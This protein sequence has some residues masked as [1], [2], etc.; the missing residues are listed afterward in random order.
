MFFLWST[1][2]QTSQTYFTLWYTLS[3]VYFIIIIFFVDVTLAVSFFHLFYINFI[4]F[5]LHWRIFF[6]SI[7]YPSHFSLNLAV[8]FFSLP[9][10]WRIFFF[11]LFYTD[12]IFR[13]F[14][15]HFMMSMF[16][17]SIR[18]LNAHRNSANKSSNENFNLMITFFYLIM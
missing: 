2:S 11:H 14:E 4:S 1:L 16:F 5:P 13:D 6:L 18:Q 8:S 3:V 10:L 12:H 17:E 7:L 9:L 15:V